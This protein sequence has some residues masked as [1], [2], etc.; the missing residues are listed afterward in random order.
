MYKTKYK[1]TQGGECGITLN[2]DWFQALDEGSSADNV[3]NKA[4]AQRQLDFVLGWMMKP[5][6]EGKYPDIMKDYVKDRLPIFDENDAKSLINSFDFIGINYYTACEVKDVQELANDPQHFENDPRCKKYALGVKST[7]DWIYV[8]EQG[9]Q[10]LLREINKY[11]KEI[12]IYVMENGIDRKGDDP[13]VDYI[14]DEMRRDYHQ[15]HLYHTLQSIKSDGV[16][17]KGY[18]TWSFLDSFE[19]SSG[20][21]RFGLCFVDYKNEF[22]RTPKQSA[23]W[24]KCFLERYQNIPK[25]NVEP[26]QATGVKRKAGDSEHGVSKK[27]TNGHHK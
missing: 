21:Q 22:K 6:T 9:L 27:V 7:S 17:V 11:G 3:A 4:A 23:A 8:Y 15:R 19:F 2:S 13:M 10:K 25:Q 12:G 20:N 5:L 14:F 24:Y 18:F 26:N 16:N 1:A